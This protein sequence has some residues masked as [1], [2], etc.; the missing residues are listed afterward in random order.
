MK[1]RAFVRELMAA[2]C[3]LQRHGKKHDIYVNPA[4]GRKV[5]V[6]RHS[7]IKDSLCE[8]IRA[9]LGLK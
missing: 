8:L 9:Q 4:N 2:G 7:E 5:P 6:P 1:R 3:R